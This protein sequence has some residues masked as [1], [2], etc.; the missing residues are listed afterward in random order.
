[1]SDDD[2]GTVNLVAFQI[3]PELM[4]RAEAALAAVREEPAQGPAVEELVEVVLEMTDRGL[5]FYY[6]EPLRR[7]E[8]GAMTTSA[9]RLG[10]AAAGRGIPAII[11]RVVR[12][13]D[14]EQILSIA[15][16]IDEI[17]VRVAADG[18]D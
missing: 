18:A 1:M 9:A 14:E 3:S 5:D 12:S 11:R 7:A 6:L 8:A 2:A 4:A 17:L 16:F 15:D 13:L 10:I